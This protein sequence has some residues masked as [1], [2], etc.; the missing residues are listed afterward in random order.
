MSNKTECRNKISK[1]LERVIQEKYIL[2][3]EMQQRFHELMG[4]GQTELL[5]SQNNKGIKQVCSKEDVT[6]MGEYF[7]QNK[8]D[9][10]KD[11]HERILEYIPEYKLDNYYEIISTEWVKGAKSRKSSLNIA[12]LEK[13]VYNFFKENTEDPDKYTHKKIIID[14]EPLFT[15]REIKYLLMVNKNLIELYIGKYASYCFNKKKHNGVTEKL[16]VTSDDIWLHRGLHLKKPLPNNTNYIENHF[17]TSYTTSV[18]IME[19]FSQIIP[20]KIPV[21]LSGKLFDLYDRVLAF[22]AFIPGMTCSQQ[23]FILIPSARK[24]TAKLVYESEK[25]LDYEL[26]YSD[27]F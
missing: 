15:I 21:L 24:T 18:S 22:Y 7:E 4:E 19:Q 16:E 9:M 11:F 17:L 6:L 23:E 10:E 13:S 8:V 3:P 12:S 1:I 27:I 25:L 2:N 5:M 20:G 14:E 26:E